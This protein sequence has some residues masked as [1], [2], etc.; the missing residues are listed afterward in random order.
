M[1]YIMATYDQAPAQPAVQYGAPAPALGATTELPKWVGVTL[2][3]G[4]VVG[5]GYLIYKGLQRPVSVKTR[6]NGKRARL[7]PSKALDSSATAFFYVGGNE[8]DGDPESLDLREGEIPLETVGRYLE[9]RL[10]AGAKV[11]VHGDK[12]VC[13]AVGYDGE[14]YSYTTPVKVES[15]RK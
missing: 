8:R 9:R 2:A 14:R 4:A 10:G 3:V 1:A 5:I 6:P 7:D 15:R 13:E 12:L 11:S